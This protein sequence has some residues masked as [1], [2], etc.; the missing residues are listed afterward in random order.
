M[1]HPP[2]PLK[3]QDAVPAYDITPQPAAQ[4]S[5]PGAMA[6]YRAFRRR[7]PLAVG[8]GVLTALVV[9]AVAYFAVPAAKYTAVGQVQVKMFQPMLMFPTKEKE[10]EFQV[11]QQT[12]TA[13][14]K[15]R[16]IRDEVL[17]DPK[18]AKLDT[19]REVVARSDDPDEWLEKQLTV[20]FV[21]KSEILQVSMSG[22]RPKD[23]EL[24]VTRMIE[25]YM[26]HNV[27][28]E[29][30]NREGRVEHLRGL[31]TRYQDN[32]RDKR[33]SLK[34]LAMTA[35]SDDRMTLTLKGQLAH[36]QLALA[37][38]E[39]MKNKTDVNKL[40]A[41]IAILDAHQKAS[42]RPAQTEQAVPDHVLDEYMDNDPESR[43]FREAVQRSRG[44]YESVSHGVR[45]GNDPAL[46]EARLKYDAAVRALAARREQLRPVVARKRTGTTADPGL[47][48]EQAKREVLVLKQFDQEMV[49]EVDRLQKAIQAFNETTQDLQTEQEEI[50]TISD[51][52]KK[53][54]SEVESMEVEMQADPRI[55]VIDWPKAPKS[56]DGMKKLRLTGTAAV[57]AFAFVLAGVTF[58]EARARRVNTPE[59]VV[60]GLGFR[61]VGSLPPPQAASRRR[62]AEGDRT[63]GSQWQSK[64]V[65]SVDA[66]R[67]M[68][69][70]AAR[71]ESLRIV[72]ITSAS[73]GEGKT[74]LACHLTASLARAGRKTLLIDCDLRRPSAH[75]LF[76]QP[77]GPGVSELLR[78]EVALNDVIR[79]TAASDLHMIP[80]GACDAQAVQALAQGGLH[81]IFDAL[82]ARYDFII[83][84]SAPVLPVV[85]SLIISQHADAVIFSILRDVSRI[86]S[87]QDARD[88]LSALGVR[89][90]GAVVSGMPGASYSTSYHAEA[91]S[92]NALPAHQS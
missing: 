1:S 37:E 15:S 69:L 56:R 8:G 78:G 39:R 17:R 55:V 4:A 64:L 81:P 30:K 53:V 26:E 58:W 33:K 43:L 86:P 48:L 77:S 65:E 52:A 67:T 80:A 61:L 18:V 79:S 91:G 36:E 59:E 25:V 84:D 49:K 62:L 28:K 40:Q 10:A 54:G 24:I 42:A 32:L 68:L 2:T 11:F 66:T 21:N 16:E 50:A 73:A 35:G 34:K 87:V 89:I 85:D 9:A 83:V 31:W 72:M 74:T 47:E 71:A 14:I 63:Y 20:N 5:T 60:Q 76:D 12:Q 90:L 46:R 88:R 51:T 38:T 22:D 75:R 27:T 44:K 45:N 13:L 29:R 23:I 6:M 7:W 57:G 92:P 70:H 82:R 41:R 3:I 19:V